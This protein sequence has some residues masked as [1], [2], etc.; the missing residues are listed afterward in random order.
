[1]TYFIIND[2]I[3]KNKPESG[4]KMDPREIN[5]LNL[6]NQILNAR[7][8]LND[9]IYEFGTGNQNPGNAALY[10]EKIRQME[11]E[12]QYM[13]NQLQM[14]KGAQNTS[15][16]VNSDMNLNKV[17]Q[18]FGPFH[19]PNNEKAAG[20][21]PDPV[22]FRPKVWLNKPER[23]T[24]DYE[25]MF[26]KS[27]MGIFASVL[28][29]ISLIIFATL[30]L[31]HLTDTIKLLGMYIV[32]LA[33]L[34]AGLLLYRKNHNNLFYIA[35]IGCGTGSLYLSLLLSNLYFKVFGDLVLYV[36]ILA[37][38]VFVRYL[39]RI[40][41]F[42]F[43]IIG[44]IGIF[45][46]SV[47][48]TILCVS[49]ADTG[50]FFVLS[51]F[52]F[53]SAVV[54]SGI[55][56]TYLKSLVRSGRNG[57]NEEN[58]GEIAEGKV[59]GG[60]ETI[61]DNSVSSM[62]REGIAN[63]TNAAAGRNTVGIT[64]YENNLITHI[65]KTLN[66]I[67][68]VMGFTFISNSVY[69]HSPESGPSFLIVLNVLLFMGYLLFEFFFS[70]KEKCRH[71]LV[72]QILTVIN[73]VLLVCLFNL[74]QL[75]DEDWAFAFMYIAAI[76]V[77]FYIEKKN[78][79][80]KLFSQIC[81]LILIF[82]ACA[83][84][85]LIEEHLYIYLTAIPF[86]LYGRWKRQ[87]VYLGAGIVYMAGLPLFI[88][89]TYNINSVE[90]LVMLA[91][92][93]GVFLYTGRKSDPVWFNAIGYIVLCLT[94]MRLVYD[95]SRDLWETFTDFRSLTYYDPET[96]ELKTSLNEMIRTYSSLT[97][98]YIIA[99]V[100]LI[101]SKLEYFGKDQ[102]IAKVIAKKISIG[103]VG[104][105]EG[106]ML[107]INAILMFAGCSLMYITDQI[108]W[109]LP[110]ILITIL[111]FLINSKNL[112]AKHKHAGF[113]I[114]FKY[115]VLMLCILNSYDVVDYATSICL[116]VFAI[117][118][119]IAGFYK[120]TISFRLYGLVLSMISI[121][122]LIMFDIKYDSTVENAVSFFVSG[123]LCFVISFI[124][125]RIDGKLRRR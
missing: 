15:V 5:F 98:F 1:M 122:K 14:L 77:L 17:P 117:I 7:K 76:T 50:K 120:D 75:L 8:R 85:T 61:N 72:F 99:I 67:V 62:D 35:I 103:K 41:H 113:Y 45:I 40:K 13:N 106:I 80:Y 20:K 38:A 6:E 59:F 23:K 21:I 12:L 49:K 24:Q 83:N 89:S 31:P 70:Y 84:N 82:I 107:G 87:N 69:R 4:I 119:I 88:W 86:M 27:F 9:L 36:L 32:S 55:G 29:F 66:V 73:T 79:E 97:T 115:T 46:A 63:S 10:Q 114:A 57:V 110:V 124:Y 71:G 109:K 93:Y 74:T 25:K 58:N 47:L 78:A 68:F 44:Q 123:V 101:L 111:L 51:I 60:I 92:L 18:N 121:V 100:H 2:N 54:F 108:P 53:I 56:K 104:T 16:S 39:T 95:I 52:Y 96:S 48:G 28:I 91:V 118:S 65:C 105:I 11:A 116:L 94:S 37:W 125:N 34:C 81:C 42:V 22:M 19:V 30:I 43:T 90:A 64:Y 26:G 3:K 33:V 112:L 102:V